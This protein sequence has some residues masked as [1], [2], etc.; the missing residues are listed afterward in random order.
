VLY[1]VSSYYDPELE[2]GIAWDDPE[3]AIRWPISDPVLSE[4]D[5][6]APSLADAAASLQR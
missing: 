2:S 3:I 5:R 6:K 4:R 1:R